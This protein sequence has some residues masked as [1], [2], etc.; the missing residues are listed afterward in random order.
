M[1]LREKKKYEHQIQQNIINVAMPQ[2]K[3]K[4]KNHNKS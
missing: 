1:S 4:M 2:M 3:T